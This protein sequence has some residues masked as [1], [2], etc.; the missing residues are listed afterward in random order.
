ME[1]TNESLENI[2]DSITSGSGMEVRYLSDNPRGLR[3]FFVWDRNRPVRETLESL[4]GFEQISL[5]V[6][7][8]TVYVK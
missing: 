2:L 5:S 4:D 7:N 8:D 6:R 3:L 1:F